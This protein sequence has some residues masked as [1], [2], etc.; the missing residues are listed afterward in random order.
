MITEQ[1]MD[2]LALA[3]RCTFPSDFCEFL[4]GRGMDDS[5]A[6]MFCEF[7]MNPYK[8]KNLLNFW[9]EFCHSPTNHDGTHNEM[10]DHFL[11]YLKNFSN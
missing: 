9:Q 8:P 1:H 10:R 2:I 7:F 5:E 11:E 3:D 4:I 6:R